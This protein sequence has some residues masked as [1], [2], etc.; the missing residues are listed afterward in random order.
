MIG[1][2]FSSRARWFATHTSPGSSLIPL[3][4][5]FSGKTSIATAGTFFFAISSPTP[6]LKIRHLLP[7]LGLAPRLLGPTGIDYGNDIRTEV[8][9]SIQNVLHGDRRIRALV[10]QVNQ[11][12]LFRDLS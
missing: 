12:C 10:R 9:P 3:Q 4:I 11:H 5:A 6:G 7:E 2:P 1:M 8:H